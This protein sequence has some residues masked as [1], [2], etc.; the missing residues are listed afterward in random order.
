MNIIQYITKIY[1]QII[2]TK[3]LIWFFI[4]IV[5][6]VPPFKQIKILINKLGT[7]INQI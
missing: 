2:L 5:T 4:N 6:L 7:K 1:H 3:K